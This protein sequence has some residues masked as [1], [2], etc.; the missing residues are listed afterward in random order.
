MARLKYK[1][2][3]GTYALF[4]PPDDLDPTIVQSSAVVTTLSWQPLDRAADQAQSHLPTEIPPTEAK[5]HFPRS[6][7]P[8]QALDRAADQPQPHLPTEIP[9]TEA[10]LQFSPIQAQEI[11]LLDPPSQLFVN[12]LPLPEHIDA[13]RPGAFVLQ[14]GQAEQ[15]LGLV[16]ANGAPLLTTIWGYGQPGQTPTYP[17][18]TIVAYEGTAIKLNWQNNLPLDGH[19]LPV[20]TTL[21]WAVSAKKPLEDGWVPTV[22]HLH[23]GHSP[24]GSDGLPEQWFTQYHSSRGPDFQDRIY[25]YPNDQEAATL[26]YHDHALG[27]TRLN[28]YA[29]L[30]GFYLL[31]DENS[32]NLISTDVLP[33]GA[34]AIEMAIQDR[35]FTIDGQLYYPAYKNDPL[36]G[37]TTDT[38]GD[39]VPQ[40]F[41]DANGE[42]A[43][44][45]VPEF[46][47][48]HILVNGMAWP[49]LNV[50]AGDYEFH[51][52][53]GSDSRFYVL[54]LSDPDVKVHLV[55]VDG[56]L[57]P[58][59][60]TIMDGDGLQ[61]KG[62][63]LVLAPGDRVD[64]VFEF[65][66]ADVDSTVRLLNV[67]P[68]F[69]PFKGLAG[70]DGSLAGGV[71]AATSDDPVGNI[72]QFTIDPNLAPFDASVTDGTV[73]N[74]GF[75][76]IA[77]DADADGIADLATYVR[78]LGLFEGVDE[79]GRIQ[80]LLGKAES[81]AINPDSM[82]PK[83]FGPLMWDAPVTE[84]P[85]LGTIEQWELFNFTED[86]HPI[87][88]HQPQFEVVEKRPIDFMDLDENGVPDDTNN[89]G[90]I[91]YG[92]G[93]ADFSQNDIW[94]GDPI[95]L[96]PEETGRQDTILVAPSEMVSIAVEFDLPGEYVWHCHILSHEDHEMMRPYEVVT[97]AAW[98]L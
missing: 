33:G 39:I 2:G 72:M 64:L 30:A 41:Y 42:D 53:N 37:N 20:D 74:P 32:Q 90:V 69:E 22:T 62:E 93:A 4:E 91:T 35:A 23:G 67:G 66:G 86:A 55:G 21:H 71:T 95:P 12:E 94:I 65:G 70:P 43:P 80:P 73:L 61:E 18:P 58:Q 96:S 84:K 50:A 26:W 57:L 56:G 45:I 40:T 60:R 17:G 27:I 14:I 48:D 97:D 88:L 16:D 36:P 1:T 3:D 59:A 92:S 31:Q 19:L 47:G 46:F 24:A 9:L 89:D 54:E 8:S 79:F 28:V 81:G 63:F 5:L 77:Q 6:T 10:Q 83:A 29:G 82:T 85:L 25:T 44:S 49:N 13:S 34:Y 87:H 76:F 78:K 7:L 68:A 51:L 15:W 11:Q 52:L 75:R 98:M 38:V